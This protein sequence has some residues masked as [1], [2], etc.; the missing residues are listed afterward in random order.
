MKQNDC[1]LSLFAIYDGIPQKYLKNQKSSINLLRLLNF[2][3]NQYTD[4]Y[5]IYKVM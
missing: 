2:M 3:E 1:F 4:K 5:L